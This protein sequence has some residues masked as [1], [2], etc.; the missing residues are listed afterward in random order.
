MERI[1]TEL[2]GVIV[3]RPR[4]IRDS[5]GYFLET[6]NQARYAAAGLPANFVQ[7]NLSISAPGVLRGLHLQW[8]GA[9][10]KLVSVLAGSVYDVTVDVRVGSPS[11]G[12]WTGVAL[13]AEDHGQLFVPAGFAHGFVVTSAVPATVAYKVD[14]PY[15]AGNELTIAWNDPELAI[16]WPLRDPVLSDKDRA[17]LRLAEVAADRLPRHDEIKGLK[18]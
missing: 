12:R 1:D 5:R 11:F 7:D 8:P 10:A 3:I 17:G 9:Q 18:P 14:A 6:W 2:P 15:A 13:S 4:I 16:D